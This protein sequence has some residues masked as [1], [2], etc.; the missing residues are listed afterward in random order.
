MH[1]RTVEYVNFNGKTVQRTFYF[2]ITKAE[3]ALREA[4]SDGTWSQSLEVIKNSDKASVVLPEFE[5]LIEWSYGDKSEDGESF[6]KSDEIWSKF[7]NSEP[8]SALVMDLLTNAASAAQFFNAILPPDIAAANRE[9][10]AVDGFR[11][12]ASTERP[13]AP[14]TGVQP[15]TRREAREAEGGGSVDGVPAR[16]VREPQSPIVPTTPE[17]PGG[18]FQ[19]PTAAEDDGVLRTS[20]ARLDPQSPQL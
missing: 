6:V 18:I 11:P 7:V 3:L 15:A 2:N 12:G 8:W 13:V 10:Q 14:V 16:D 5:K 20:T 9:A 17:I 1:S 4:R 19:V